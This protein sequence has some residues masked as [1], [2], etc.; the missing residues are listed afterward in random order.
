LSKVSEHPDSGPGSIS[1]PERLDLKRAFQIYVEGRARSLGPDEKR[2]AAAADLGPATS[3]ASESGLPAAPPSRPR[4][5]VPVPEQL[6]FHRNA[7][8][9]LDR[10]ASGGPTDSGG[11]SS[12]G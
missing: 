1:L 7:G 8:T 5:G 10:P 12:G 11:K 6:A 4:F 3:S 9:W 2:R